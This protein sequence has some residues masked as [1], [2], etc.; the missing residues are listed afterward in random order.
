MDLEKVI[1]FLSASLLLS[2]VFIVVLNFIG[3]VSFSTNIS[4]FSPPNIKSSTLNTVLGVVLGFGASTFLNLR[5]ENRKN[6]NQAINTRKA[7]ISEL[8]SMN[9]FFVVL[10]GIDY[11]HPQSD[12]FSEIV[13]TTSYESNLPQIGNLTPVEVRKVVSFYSALQRVR[14]M[15]KMAAG[16]D[17]EDTITGEVMG[18]DERTASLL[19]NMWHSCIEELRK[20]IPPEKR[21]PQRELEVIE[22]EDSMESIRDE[23]E[24]ILRESLDVD[25]DLN[26][27]VQE[28]DEA[29]RD[30]TVST[31]D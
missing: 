25:V 13:S 7:L 12:K 20:N 22:A 30:D 17:P 9:L 10:T 26:E 16:T 24:E 21:P 3:L 18:P 6:R 29:V 5:Q 28:A 1:R 8:E 14:T 27:A 23:F 31:T 15:I 2:I 19:N 11:S 4:S